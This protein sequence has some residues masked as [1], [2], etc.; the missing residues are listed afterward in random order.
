MYKYL[1][2]HTRGLRQFGIV[3]KEE[4]DKVE[5]QFKG[6]RTTVK[7]SSED[8]K[9]YL[10]S[11]GNLPGIEGSMQAVGKTLAGSA[12]VFKNTWEGTLNEIGKALESTFQS[13]TD[14]LTSELKGIEDKFKSINYKNNLITS[15]Q[16][17]SVN[18]METNSA[19]KLLNKYQNLQ[20]DGLKPTAEKK[21]QLK[22]ITDQL[23]S[24]FGDNILQLDKETKSMILNTK[25]CKR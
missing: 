5:F 15:F 1:F 3:A 16:T 13:S 17:I 22:E 25:S 6:V 12:I 10:L 20:K 23:V 14:F 18:K 7:N 24:I 4:K 21:H 19:Q 2:G 11:I 9:K 8:I